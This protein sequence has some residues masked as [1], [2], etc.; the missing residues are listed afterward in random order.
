MKKG[1][2]GLFFLLAIQLFGATNEQVINSKIQSVTVYVQGAEIN[3]MANVSMTKGL[4]TIVF[5]DLTPYLDQNTIQIGGKGNFT[6]LSVNYRGN[7]L[8]NKPKP[9]KL[10]EVEEKLE[11]L[12]DQ[13]YLNNEE[14][15]TYQQEKKLILNNSNL[16]S[17]NEAVSADKLKA[18]ADFYRVRLTE[19]AKLIIAKNKVEKKLNEEITKYTNQLN[20][21]HSHRNKQIGEVVVEVMA[22]QTVTGNLK[23]AYL[24]QQAGWAP[25]Y[26]VRSDNGS[27]S[28]DVNFNARVFQTT[29][30]DWSNTKVKLSTGYPLRSNT[31]PTIHPWVLR[32]GPIYRKV[33]A[34]SNRAFAISAESDDAFDAELDKDAKAEL[35]RM[36]ENQLATEYEIKMKYSVPSN[37]KHHIMLVRKMK[38]PASYEY[39]AAPKK[40]K[41][42]FLLGRITGW[43]EYNLIPGDA[44]LFY[45]G[46]YIGKSFLNTNTTS[47]TLDISLGRSRGIVL[48]RNRIKD[49]TEK[50]VIGSSK[51]ETIGIQVKVR[52]TRKQKVKMR[53]QDQIPISSDKEIDVELLE[54]SGAKLDKS[55][56]VL[57]WEMELS[58]GETKVMKFKYSVK[59]PKEKKINL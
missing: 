18:M 55:T 38:L 22:N 17:E 4:N 10:L 45:D 12:K 27:E 47:D 40:D 33:A 54:S 34:Y 36:I 2:T 9:Q 6:I 56:G 44:N 41:D 25:Q 16:T 21:M 37:G 11:E 13:K 43:D 3:R 42:A 29:G 30:T 8:K 14:R 39:Y 5:T 53:V 28:I 31:K 15:S 58:P 48:E 49:Y 26:E 46:T 1:L 59:Y 20:E 23:L 50:R 51:K 35:G 7:Y 57:T 32:F 19:L 52:N 24:S